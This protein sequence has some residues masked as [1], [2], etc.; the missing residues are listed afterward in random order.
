MRK[1]SKIVHLVYNSNA[2]DGENQ[3][4]KELVSMIE[5]FGYKCNNSSATKKSLKSI[6]PL[7][8]FIIVAG[9]DG[10]IREV[11]MTLLKNQLKHNR[12]MALLPFGTAN[13]IANSLGISRDSK[14]NIQSWGNA[15]PEKIDVGQIVGL[16][17]K[18]Y[19]LESFG[20]GLFSK[21]LRTL[22]NRKEDPDQSRKDEFSMAIKK[23]LQITEDYEG[24]PFKI[25]TDDRVIEA[26]FILIEVMNISCLG[27]NL[28]LSNKAD[29][30]DGYM[31]V[32]I[33]SVEQ[34]PLLERYLERRGHR[35]E[36][37]FPIKPIQTKKLTITG[38]GR[39]MHVDD[40]LLDD[41]KD[42]RIHISLLSNLLAIIR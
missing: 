12:P 18:V 37:D 29:P 35:K 3:S 6:D 31:D 2:G 42:V 1:T 20:F 27:P 23:L 26:E 25:E 36:I 40:E 14:T 16:S 32:V 15:K 24:S 38:Q 4:K 28:N 33:V 22:E 17:K 13:N 5:T 19:F 10:T 34:R 9:G 39:N 30:Q 41:E 7:T 21:L 11:A 8:E